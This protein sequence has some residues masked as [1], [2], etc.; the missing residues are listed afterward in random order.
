MIRSFALSD[1]IV[2]KKNF[3]EQTQVP[4]VHTL[5]ESDT[6]N[7]RA[8]DQGQIHGGEPISQSKAASTTSRNVIDIEKLSVRDKKV[9]TTTW[10]S[11][12]LDAS[13]DAQDAVEK[14]KSSTSTTVISGH[15]AKNMFPTVS[16]TG[17]AYFMGL[18][19]A[20]TA[21]R[22]VSAHPETML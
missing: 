20:A 7:S 9:L 22:R 18:C 5:E 16:E 21:K 17:A 11:Q 8:E 6:E 2:D 3:Q 13:R 15:S 12:I 4:P 14:R 1:L 10:I 19:R